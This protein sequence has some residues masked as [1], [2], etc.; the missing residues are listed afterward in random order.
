LHVCAGT[1]AAVLV[2]PCSTVLTEMTESYDTC[3]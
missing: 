1:I 2:Q 3:S